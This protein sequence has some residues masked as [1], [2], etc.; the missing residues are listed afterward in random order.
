MILRRAPLLF[1]LSILLAGLVLPGPLQAKKGPRKILLMALAPTTNASSTRE[2]PRGARFGYAT[3]NAIDNEP[4]TAWCGGAQMLGVNEW[5][6]VGLVQQLE[7][8][9]VGLIGTIPR[10]DG[11]T[12]AEASPY[13]Y[14]R[15]HRVRLENGLGE[16]RMLEFSDIA[17]R[18][19]QKLDKPL[20]GERFR[21]KIESVYPGE[22]RALTC[23]AELELLGHSQPAGAPVDKLAARAIESDA[24]KVFEEAFGTQRP[25]LAAPRLKAA[26]ADIFGRYAGYSAISVTRTLTEVKLKGGKGEDLRPDQTA[27]ATALRALYDASPDARRFLREKYFFKKTLPLAEGCDLPGDPLYWALRTRQESIPLF[28]HRGEYYGLLELGDDRAIAPFLAA[29]EKPDQAAYRWWEKPAGWHGSADDTPLDLFSR[30][31]GPYARRTLERL[32]EENEPSFYL[33]GLRALQGNVG[34]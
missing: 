26:L 9:A 23:I 32:I 16:F 13:P 2:D 12:P 31:A 34:K 1:S 24:Q 17:G 29:Y 10:P 33:D 21:F 3:L 7:L 25:A 28:W 8:Q 5:F 19:E 4:R 22:D 18:T 27:C 6:E 30:V 11:K 20:L 14:N 15:I